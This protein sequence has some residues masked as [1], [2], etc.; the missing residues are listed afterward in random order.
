MS[1]IRNTLF[2]ENGMKVVNLLFF[3]SVFTR[4]RGIIFIAYLAW[5]T[6]LVFGIKNTQSKTIKVINSVFIVFAATMVIVNACL[7]LN[8]I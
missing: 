5:I 7:Y 2:S 6:Y 1:R 8:H 4:N 3:V